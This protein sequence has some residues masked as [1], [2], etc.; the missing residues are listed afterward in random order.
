MIIRDD[1]TIAAQVKLRSVIQKA[2]LR[3]ARQGLDKFDNQR[4]FLR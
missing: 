2:K 3:E 4:C 1:R